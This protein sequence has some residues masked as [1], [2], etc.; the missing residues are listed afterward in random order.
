VRQLLGVLILGGLVVGIHA[1][2]EDVRAWQNDYA[3]RIID[4]P[5]ELESLIAETRN[6]GERGRLVAGFCWPWSNP[7]ADGTLIPD[8][9]IDKWARPWNAK[10]GKKKYRPEDDP[11]TL[12]AD[13]PVG[14]SQ[15][16][17][18]YSAQGF[19]F[20][21]VGVIWGLDL[22]WRDD[23]WLAQRKCS[24]DPPVK[25]RTADTQRLIRNAYRVLLTRGIKE[26]RVLILDPETKSHVH[27]ALS[28]AG[29]GKVTMES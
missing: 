26:T 28:G 24:F 4:T 15:I 21:R 5:S 11:Y 25:A 10:R 23:N 29:Y 14:E 2:H 18:I 7:L 17:C 27:Q 13:T 16:G 9:T 6:S 1:T 22:V 20:D 3:F 8:V 19:E 12:W